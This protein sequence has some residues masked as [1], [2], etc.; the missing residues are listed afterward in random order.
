MKK[1]LIFG[2]AMLAAGLVFGVNEVGNKNFTGDINF[3][4]AL[5]I[6]GT[7]VTATAAQLNTGIGASGVSVT[8]VT[9]AVGAVTATA[10]VTKQTVSLTDTNGVTALVVTN[11]TVAVTIVGGD[12]V[13]TNITVQ[14]VP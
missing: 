6:K 9:K 1:G 3:E 11:C 2:I 4:G 12:A 8:N 13:V 7:K 10:V 14:R 5:Q